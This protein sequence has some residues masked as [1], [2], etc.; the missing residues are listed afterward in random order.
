MSP[1]KPKTPARPFLNRYTSLPVLLDILVHKRIVLLKPSSWEDRNDSFYL[2]RYKDE[3]KLRTVLALCFSTKRE[4]FHHWK[5]FSAGSGG[6]CVEFDKARLLD[7]LTEAAG[8]TLRKVDYAFIT[9]VVLNRPKLADWPFLKRKPFED[10]GEFRI[11]YENKTQDEPTKAIPIPLAC[12]RRI[13]LSPWLPEAV[14]QTV[15][16]VLKQLPDCAAI[17]VGRSSLLET[18]RWKAVVSPTRTAR[19]RAIETAD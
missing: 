18:S 2:E 16:K 15:S 7:G 1:K 8:F 11:V 5:I 9:E 17:Q 4:T 3:K 10:E 19:G 12:I 13:T 14:A 6:V